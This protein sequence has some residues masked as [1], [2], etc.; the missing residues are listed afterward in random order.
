LFVK[1]QESLHL[2][3]LLYMDDMKI[4]GNEATEVEKLQ[5]EHTIKF[6][7]KKLREVHHFL[8][9]KVTNLAISTF[10]SKKFMLRS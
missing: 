5:D 2:I 10:L 1:K 4:I 8:G 9:L 7:I 3:V 6:D